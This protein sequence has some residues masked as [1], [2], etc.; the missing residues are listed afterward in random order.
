MVNPF[1]Y[2]SEIFFDLAT[3]LQR[4]V[5]HSNML[6]CW[7]S[8][9]KAV[10]QNRKH[11]TLH[12]GVHSQRVYSEQCRILPARPMTPNIA[13]FIRVKKMLYLRLITQEPHHE[14]VWGCGGVAA[15]ILNLGTRW[16]WVVSLK[17]RADLTS[18]ESWVDP[19]FGRSNRSLY[20]DWAI[21]SP[22]WQLTFLILRK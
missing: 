21:E 20:T 10:L 19:R 1:K 7:A 18:V 11:F 8:L 6:R 3:R 2:F 9:F 17:L 22:L 15:L 12:Q 5:K 13:F 16:R 14:D 4:K